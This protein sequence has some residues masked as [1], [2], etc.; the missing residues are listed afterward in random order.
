MGLPAKMPQ[1]DLSSH[2]AVFERAAATYDRVGVSY[3]ADIGR[4]LVDA[5]RLQLGESVLDI[6]CGRGAVL[7]PAS[8][9]VGPGGHAVGVD[10]APTMVALTAA[11]LADRPQVA[12][13]QADAASLPEDLGTFDAVLSSLV[14]FFC[15]DPAAVLH[16]WVRHVA[17]GGRLGLTTFVEDRRAGWFNELIH[18]FADPSP[19]TDDGPTP[20]DLVSDPTWLDDT[21]ATAGLG[22]IEGRVHRQE[23]RFDDVDQWW[24]WMWSHGGRAALETVLVQRHDALKAAAAA[25][26]DADRLPDGSLGVASRIRT[27]IGRAT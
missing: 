23:V 15:D 2:A 25:E 4:R 1:V 13:R 7:D 20:F 9:A 3:F 19:T 24:A 21:L 5:A 10:L 26:L 27:T 14:L 17:P 11:D 8:E 6:G 22:R 18:R 16:G 12:V